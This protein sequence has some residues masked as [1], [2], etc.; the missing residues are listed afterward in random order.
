M[1]TRSGAKFQ[2]SMTTLEEM[3]RELLQ[4]R[5]RRE[6]LREERQLREEELRREQTRRDEEFAQLEEERQLRTAELRREAA[7]RE[8]EMRQQMELLR[9]LV[10]GIHKQGE[11]AEKKVEKDRDVKVAKL[12]WRMT[13]RPI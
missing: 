4:D 9:G 12:T 5:Q 13:W 8:E 11:I 2:R 1:T 6:E 7:T 3:C 10:Q